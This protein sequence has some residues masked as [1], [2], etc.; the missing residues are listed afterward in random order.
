MIYVVVSSKHE[1]NL[2]NLK[3]NKINNKNYDIYEKENL[4]LIISGLG[5]YNVSSSV[6]YLC[7][8]YKP[9][10][11]DLIINF[12]FSASKEEKDIN[13]IFRINEIFDSSYE[14]KYY[15]DMVY[16]LNLEEKSLVTVKKPVVN[17]K[18]YESKLYD[19]EGSAFF[20]TARKF[21]ERQN[22]FILKHVSDTGHENFNLENI[23]K[24]Y[25]IDIIFEKL[26]N[27][28]ESH[29][30][31]YKIDESGKIKN[32][33]KKSEFTKV[34][35]DL[36]LKKLFKKVLENQEIEPMLN[37]LLHKKFNNKKE[38]NSYF[39]QIIKS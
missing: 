23:Q 4:K 5:A 27:I 39:E 25:E 11:S 10:K 33:L 38:R 16:N 35:K 8:I 3:L 18:I 21:F 19:M 37:D 12:G 29:K 9:K 15:L 14:E 17:N 7:G 2:L 22:I 28:N 26:Y 20:F 31:M 32:S 30:K 24:N 1:K 6:A 13:N 34:Q 36:L